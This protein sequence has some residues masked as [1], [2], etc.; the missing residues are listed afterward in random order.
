MRL[1]MFLEMGSGYVCNFSDKTFKD[2]VLEVTGIDIYA[3]GYEKSGTSKANRLRTFWKKEDDSVTAKL[4]KEIVEYQKIQK[5]TSGKEWNIHDEEQ[6]Q[7]CLNIASNIQEK[8]TGNDGEFAITA[9]DTTSNKIIS[10][11][12][13]R[14][15]II[16]SL[17]S[18]GYPEESLHSVWKQGENEF[19]LAI[20]DPVTKEILIVFLFKLYLPNPA[21]ISSETVREVIRK[22]ASLVIGEKTHLYFVTATKGDQSFSVTKILTH[23]RNSVLPIFVKIKELPE[24]KMLKNTNN[25]VL[26]EQQTELQYRSIS[27]NKPIKEFTDDELLVV[28][29]QAENTNVPGILYQKA[30]NEWQIRHQ[31]KMLEATQKPPQ[32]GTPPIHVSGDYVGGDKVMKDKIVSKKIG[33]IDGI[34]LWLQYFV[35]FAAV[36]SLCWAIY[37]YFYPSPQKTDV[38]QSMVSTTTP[39]DLRNILIGSIFDL[40]EE[41]Q[42][43]DKELLK[44]DFLQNSKGR[45]FE[46]EGVV[47]EIGKFE[48][49]EIWVTIRGMATDGNSEAVECHFDD[50]WE[51]TLRSLLS[52]SKDQIKFGGEIGHYTKGWLVAQNCKILEVKN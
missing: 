12:V 38:A 22:F 13:L 24:F 11:Y 52:T 47:S 41:I 46:A 17:L 30:Y 20:I 6:Y 2:F 42:K 40:V 51:K 37:I 45:I 48:N 50:S 33:S 14:D 9:D 19:D 3:P 31:Q 43:I 25:D 16:K 10:E 36:A 23:T 5:Q 27:M 15:E 4:L 8:G 34:P 28:I 44:D 32:S 7:T 1:E 29:R 26:S 18:K 39:T 49:G 35:A 21:V